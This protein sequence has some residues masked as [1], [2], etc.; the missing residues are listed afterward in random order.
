MKRPSGPTLK[1][2]LRSR[3]RAGSAEHVGY[4]IARYVGRLGEE[5]AAAAT[6]QDVL[7]YVAELRRA[8]LHAR[9]LR[10]E[11]AAVKAY[12]AWLVEVGRRADH[13]CRSMHLRDQVD[14]QIRLDGLYSAEQLAA[15]AT[16]YRA[17]RPEDQRR[18]EVIVGLLVHQALTAGD[19]TR[20]RVGDIDLE[21]GTVYVAAGGKTAER[22]LRLR[23]SQVIGLW[24][25]ASED[26]ARYV[27]L[28]GKAGA[29]DDWLV[30]DTQGGQLVGGQLHRLVNVGRAKAEKLKP[31]RIRQS[32][33][34]QL[35][36]AGHELRVVQAFAGH[37]RSSATEQ[38]R[39]TGAE[40]LAE[41][42]AKYHPRSRDP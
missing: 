17:A 33:I 29:R 7:A 25:Y 26:R 34:A 16:S 2:Y 3:F 35:V 23:A 24:R 32:V 22:T 18:G 40:E 9:T 28:A 8:G 42:V 14:R 27:A 15:W 31:Q 13:P 10:L 6:Y 11:L 4:R 37:R 30:F 41:A 19:V 20:L 12:H 36:A 1:D 5:G 21:A 39:R 38:Y